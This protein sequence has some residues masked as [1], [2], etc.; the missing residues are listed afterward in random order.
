[1]TDTARLPQFRD[2]LKTIRDR[3]EKTHRLEDAK[4][5]FG[6]LDQLDREVRRTEIRL[7]RGR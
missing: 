3:N 4:A 2:Y 6:D 1:M 5:S 7:Q